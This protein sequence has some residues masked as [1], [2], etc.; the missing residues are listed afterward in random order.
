M[1]HKKISDKHLLNIFSKLIIPYFE[2]WIKTLILTENQ[3]DYNNAYKNIPKILY[4]K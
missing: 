1:I 3:L 4:L 2:Y